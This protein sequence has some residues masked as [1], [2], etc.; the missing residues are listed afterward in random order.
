MHPCAEDLYL[1]AAIN[2]GLFDNSKTLDDVTGSCPTDQCTWDPYFTMAICTSQLEDVTSTIIDRGGDNSPETNYRFSVPALGNDPRVSSAAEGI[3]FWMRSLYF[4]GSSNTS[5]E[6]ALTLP[7]IEEIVVLFA[8]PCAI[9]KFNTS[10]QASWTAFRGTLSLCLQK[11]NSTYIDGF[12]NTTV[13]YTY[14]DINWQQTEQDVYCGQLNN[15]SERYCIY[16][17]ENIAA[18]I[19][20]FFTG[21]ASLKPGGDNYYSSLPIEVLATDILGT[22]P[23]ICNNKSDI[24]LH[25]FTRRLNTTA[26]ALTNA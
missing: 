18:E 7:D 24:G 25:G 12:M 6:T 10:L 17:L 14:R 23:T 15:T 13:L 19:A 8:S 21:N 3:T 22:D 11:L 26:L 2:A 9:A 16:S 20:T 5:N 4:G 1:A